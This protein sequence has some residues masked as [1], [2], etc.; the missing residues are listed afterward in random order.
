LLERQSD[1]EVVL[2]AADRQLADDG[3]KRHRR[4]AEECSFTDAGRRS[5]GSDR[6][7]SGSD[8]LAFVQSLAESSKKLSESHEEVTEENAV[9]TAAG[10][11]VYHA[12]TRF[13]IAAIVFRNRIP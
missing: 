4:N 11:A 3:E 5:S 8:L 7:R 6:S 13:F 12:D 9:K 1:T 2:R 10:R